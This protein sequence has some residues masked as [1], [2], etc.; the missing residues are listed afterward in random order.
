MVRSK[1]FELFGGRLAPGTRHFD[2]L[3][4][5][6]ILAGQAPFLKGQI[7]NTA[8]SHQ[9]AAESTWPRA[10]VNDPVGS[11]HGV[12]I[13]FHNNHGIPSVPQTYQSMDQTVVIAWVEANRWLIQDICHTHK[14]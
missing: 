9:F 10:E 2:P 11:A 12:F 13:M 14:P 7:F 1:H 8:L 5:G 4:A 3:R 6:Q